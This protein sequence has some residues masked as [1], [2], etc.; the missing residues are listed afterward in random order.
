VQTLLLRAAYVGLL[1][2]ATLAPFQ[3]QLD[4]SAALVHLSRAF[5]PAYSPT[6]FVDAVRNVALFAGWGA[7]WTITA[8]PGRP[9]DVLWPPL[10]SG[11]VLSIAI[12][13]TQSLTP[14]RT[15]SI[16]DVATNGLGALAGALLIVGL[17]ALVRA[18]RNEKSHVG[19]PG[20]LFA[21]AYLAA[22]ALEAVFAP[23]R[24][25]PISGIHGGPLTRLAGT[26]A[27]FEGR[28]LYDL[29][30]R[31]I[32]LFLP[33]GGLAV[34]AL[35]E[36]GRSHRS[37]ARLTIV[38]GTG[39]WVVAELLHGLLALP[40]QLG[41]ILVHVISTA[42][43][44]WLAA[45]FL[46][47]LSRSLRGRLRP[48][49]LFFLYGALLLIWT[50]RPGRVADDVDASAQLSWRRLVPLQGSAPRLDL[51]SV[52]DIA[53]GFLLYFPVGCLLA[54][55]PMRRRGYLSSYLPGVIIAVVGELGQ[56]LIAGRYFD[57]TDILVEVAGMGMG[58]AIVRRAGFSAYGEMMPAS[59]GREVHR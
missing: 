39:L 4:L 13:L 30:L 55:W 17:V 10:W 51:Y 37:A 27:Q 43:G 24:L 50:W 35:V 3:F 59:P 47:S 18:L 52:A 46:P 33:A 31:D 28:S 48:L 20:V 22:L 34:A 56:P 42:A 32:L 15:S 38:A 12:E 6:D 1:L 36:L 53:E 2:L 8:P 9:R 44:A 14:R 5:S 41:A 23:F 26:L 54:V 45:R 57:V 40:I 16:L 19:V 49:Y 7:L 11:L 21:G 29:P 58:W 25:S